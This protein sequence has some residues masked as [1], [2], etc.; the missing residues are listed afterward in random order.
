MLKCVLVVIKLQWMNS[1]N[2]NLYTGITHIRNM[3]YVM[4]FF[5]CNQAY[6]PWERKRN[7]EPYNDICRT[8]FIVTFLRTHQSKSLYSSTSSP[9]EKTA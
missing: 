3:S 5:P 7:A 9:S 2:I 8:A 6:F 1:G 4:T